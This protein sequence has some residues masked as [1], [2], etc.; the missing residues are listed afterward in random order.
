MIAL[1]IGVALVQIDLPRAPKAVIALPEDA[2]SEPIAVPVS[3]AVRSHL[4]GLLAVIVCAMTS[5]FASVYFE[6]LL[7]RGPP[8]RAPGEANKATRPEDLEDGVPLVSAPDGEPRRSMALETDADARPD[9]PS[10][11]ALSSLVI[12]NVLLSAYSA[13][14]LPFVIVLSGGS[15][16]IGD[17]TR[18]FGPLVWAI[19]LMTAI[20]GLVIALVIRCAADFSGR[21]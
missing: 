6:A 13:A 12:S 9:E 21:R 15:L 7:K 20:G 11:P 3:P 10:G 19:V 4:L 1:T 18:G 16:R 17:L 14:A 8:V 5:G 2:E